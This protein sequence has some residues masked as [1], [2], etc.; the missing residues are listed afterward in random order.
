MQEIYEAASLAVAQRT[1]A[2][3]E[4]PKFADWFVRGREI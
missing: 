4:L 1:P 3:L 2:S